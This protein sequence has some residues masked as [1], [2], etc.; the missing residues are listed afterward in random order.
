MFK[1]EHKRLFD[2]TRHGQMNLLSFGI[3]IQGDVNVACACPI[4]GNFV[5]LF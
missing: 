4:K 2:V 3:P 5:V 1:F